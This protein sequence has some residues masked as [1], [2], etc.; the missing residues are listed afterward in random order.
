MEDK[1]INVSIFSYYYRVNNMVHDQQQNQTT[2][3]TERV[4]RKGPRGMGKT[5]GTNFSSH[6]EYAQDLRNTILARQP[7]PI[8]IETQSLKSFSE[9]LEGCNSDL[10]STLVIFLLPVTAAIGLWWHW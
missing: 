5:T 6:D 3:P 2:P 10:L 4:Y 7:N 8:R 1:Y 9:F